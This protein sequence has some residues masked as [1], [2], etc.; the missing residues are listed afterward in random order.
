MSV[1][2]GSIWSSRWVSS[3]MRRWRLCAPRRTSLLP[4]CLPPRDLQ[5]NRKRRRQA[6]PA[7]VRGTMYEVRFGKFARLRRGCAKPGRSSMFVMGRN[8]Y[9]QAYHRFAQ[10]GKKDCNILIINSSHG[11]ETEC[12]HPGR[13]SPV[14]GI[15]PGVAKIVHLSK[16]PSWIFRGGF[17]M[18][19][20]C[21]ILC[22]SGFPGNRLL[23]TGFFFL[24][25]NEGSFLLEKG[26]HAMFG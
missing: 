10:D 15:A 3:P 9:A 4:F 7:Y 25:A 24:R 13:R 5:R 19:R 12:S 11:G 6:E 16:I 2:T 18:G 8:L 17:C 14:Y 26:A 20:A 21:P 22:G 1:N 23:G